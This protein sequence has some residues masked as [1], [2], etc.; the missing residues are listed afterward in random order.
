M[1][2]DSSD[3]TVENVFVLIHVRIFVICCLLF[4]DSFHIDS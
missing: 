2:R 3:R 1:D 4:S